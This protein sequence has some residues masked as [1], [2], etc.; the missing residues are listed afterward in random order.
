MTNSFFFNSVGFSLWQKW[1]KDCAE[2]CLQDM[3]LPA[4]EALH[5]IYITYQ[6]QENAES[7]YHWYKLLFWDFFS[8]LLLENLY[9][10][11]LSLWYLN[12]KWEFIEL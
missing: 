12:L 9:L 5:N 7:S 6:V 4:E 3:F 10:G 1:K 11:V 2:T 8:T